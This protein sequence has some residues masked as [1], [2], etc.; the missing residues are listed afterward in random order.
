[1]AVSG[2][3]LQYSYLDNLGI[4]DGS[5][6]EQVQGLSVG[7][8]ATSVQF[9]VETV[10]GV[11][12]LGRSA[13]VPIVDNETLTVHVLV[14]PLDEVGLVSG[15]PT[16]L[17]GD[18]CVAADGAGNIFLVGGTSAREAGYVYD[19]TF[20]LRSFG[21]ELKGVGG[22]GC[23]AFQGAVAAVGGCNDQQVGDVQLIQVDGTTTAFP[24]PLQVLCGAMAAPA[25]DGGVWVI[26]G[27]GTVS[28]RDA[29]NSVQFIDELGA[30]P[31]AVE[32]TADGNL[33]V[34]SGG[35]AWHVSSTELTELS[36]A[37]ALGRRG[38]GVFILDDDGDIKY[39][40]EAKAQ[41]RLRGGIPA[42]EHFVVLSDDTVVGLAGAVVSVVVDD[43]TTTL[44]TRE[45]T[46]IVGLPGDTVVLAGA[47]GPGFDG[48]SRR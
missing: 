21:G 40:D 14:A 26:D 25:A 10:G 23:G 47:A 15:A 28:L 48:F 4:G 33:V 9:T 20:V 37:L 13:L 7:I 31:Q 27:D 16:N 18:A 35:K 46:A 36:P 34:L 2:G 45:H 3:S 43:S 8:D 42:F 32:V 29:G 38:D 12:G 24:V 17:G 30:E 44:T 39:V 19:T 11:P 1:V 22:L 41:R 6:V 5:G